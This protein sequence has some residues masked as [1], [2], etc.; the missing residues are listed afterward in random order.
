MANK[1]DH[2]GY[3]TD[4]LDVDVA[5]LHLAQD[6]YVKFICS[7]I[8]FLISPVQSLRIASILLRLHPLPF[9]RCECIVHSGDG[10]VNRVE[11]SVAH[12]M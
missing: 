8:N 7:L 1:K 6:E 5:N 9:Y 11:L 2:Y 4:E 10:A 12:H 3:W